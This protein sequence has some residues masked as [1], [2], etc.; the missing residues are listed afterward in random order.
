[1]TL[2]NQIRWL[3]RINAVINW[4]L[5]VRGIIDPVGMASMFGGPESNYLFLV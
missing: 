3:F 4:V 2:D 1:M 5:S